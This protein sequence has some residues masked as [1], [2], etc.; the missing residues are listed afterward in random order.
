MVYFAEAENGLIKIGYSRNVK[1][2]LLEVQAEFGWDVKLV[3][4]VAGMRKEEL[5]LH[6]TFGYLRHHR[7]WFLPGACL[8]EFI[9][10]KGRP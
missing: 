8:L 9:D 3:G 7:E 1:K 2:R 6:K 4:K 5:K 10:K